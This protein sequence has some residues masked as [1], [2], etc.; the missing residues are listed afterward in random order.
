[1]WDP[2]KPVQ[3]V[4]TILNGTISFLVDFDE[5]P[6]VGYASFSSENPPFLST[7]HPIVR[8]YQPGYL[9]EVFKR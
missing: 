1:M 4:T 3:P 7:L 9:E 6:K 8:M 5:A 2:R